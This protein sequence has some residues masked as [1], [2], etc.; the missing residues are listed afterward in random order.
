MLQ[1]RIQLGARQVLALLVLTLGILIGWS[2]SGG[3]QGGR[4]AH[5]LEID[6]AIGPASSDYLSRSFADAAE[7]G[8]AMIIIRMD[9]PGGL[10]TSMRE[11]IRD[12][13]ASPVPVVTY[14]AP[15][16]AR[17]ASAGTYI[18]Y[19][20]HVAAMAPGTNMGA[21]TPVQ[22]G[23][24]GS[25]GGSPD[26]GNQAG[27]E[28]EAQGGTAMER[29]AV[30]DAVAYI[31]SLAELRDRNAD[32]AEQ[33]VR[34]GASLSASAA[35]RENVI[36][37]VAR[38]MGELLQQIDGRTVT[39]AGS[40][41]TIDTDNL[42]LVQVE[43]NWRTRLLNAITNP[44]VALI[45][46]MI[47]IYGLIF[48][49][50]NPGA[51]YP[52][53]IGVVSLLLG[54]YALA[55]LPVTFAGIALI[56]LGLAMI[57]AE[58]FTPSFGV[59][60]IAGAVAL[61]FG[62]TILVDTDVPEFQIGWP[63]AAGI[64]VASLAIVLVIARFALSSR[65]ARIV[66]GKEDMIGAV[67]EVLEWKGSRGH[68]FVHGERWRARGVDKLKRGDAVEVLGIDGLTLTVGSAPEADAPEF[69]A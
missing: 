10:D 34:T 64:A 22:I 24:G 38:D 36:D 46:M 7:Q 32:W 49:F 14:V 25:P 45:L 4:A 30:N 37:F 33:A 5:V 68:V 9:T 29:K 62:A 28:A 1:S 16:G 13:L 58:A 65:R 61:A 52:G 19:A 35:L 57:A 55:A 27:N 11:M 47:G 20:S 67:G 6:G 51:L 17:A 12:I 59:L 53:T 60:G 54:L 3:A 15:S 8:A 39:A 31:R 41:V 2:G 56:L 21:A 48:E 66:S 26:D 42:R 50:M 18:L 69:L 63:V 23:G 43:P 44:N 40:E